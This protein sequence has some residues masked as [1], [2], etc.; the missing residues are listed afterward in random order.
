MQENN[1]SND[2]SKLCPV[3][4]DGKHS[5]EVKLDSPGHHGEK[6]LVEIFICQ[7]CGIKKPIK[8]KS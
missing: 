1:Q 5:W 8:A 3:N 4:E 2:Q 7:A 6:K